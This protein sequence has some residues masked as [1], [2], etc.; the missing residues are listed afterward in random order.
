MDPCASRC[1]QEK[2][3]QA[4]RSYG[5]NGNG[6]QLRLQG[7]LGRQGQREEPF[8]IEDVDPEDDLTDWECELGFE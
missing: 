8:D 2:C 1:Y 3:A 5:P 6:E 7:I 4:H